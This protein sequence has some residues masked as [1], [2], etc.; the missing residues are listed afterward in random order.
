MAAAFEEIP[1]FP[2][3]PKGGAGGFPKGGEGGIWPG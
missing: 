3:L 2:P 1:L